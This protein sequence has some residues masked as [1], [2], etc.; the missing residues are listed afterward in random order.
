M[1]LPQ[2]LHLR[3]VE[4]RKN[5]ER[6]RRIAFEMITH[7]DITDAQVLDTARRVAAS[8]QQ[9]ESMRRDLLRIAEHKKLHDME[10][11]LRQG[12]NY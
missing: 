11:A 12:F 10:R 2:A 9:L 3:W 4:L 5:H 1:N 7:P 8:Q 6:L